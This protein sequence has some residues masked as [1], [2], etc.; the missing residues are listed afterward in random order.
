MFRKS[1][2]SKFDRGALRF[3]RN[4]KFIAPKGQELD[5]SQRRER[6][7]HLLVRTHGMT[8]FAFRFY[9]LTEPLPA[10]CHSPYESVARDAEIN[11]KAEL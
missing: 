10:I 3:A 1:G 11:A 8:S 6:D 2:N 5:E 7:G 4:I 9:E